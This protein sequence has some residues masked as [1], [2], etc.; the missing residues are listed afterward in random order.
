MRLCG[1]G[2]RISG[3]LSVDGYSSQ[4]TVFHLKYYVHMHKGFGDSN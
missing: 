4:G 2:Y 3:I 1:S